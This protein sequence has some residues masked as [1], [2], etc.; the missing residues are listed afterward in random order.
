M[1]NTPDLWLVGCGTMAVEYAKVLVKLRKEFK[2]VGRGKDTAASFTCAT[3]IPVT[4]GGV[5]S[6]LESGKAPNTAIVAV[7]VE[8]LGIVTTTLLDY[9]VKNILIEKPGSLYVEELEKI[10]RIE[11]DNCG[12]IYIAYNRRFYESVRFLKRFY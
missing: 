8:E 9:G 11:K 10:R 1:N 12:K 4:T 5:L 6:A 3:N 2:V 7:P